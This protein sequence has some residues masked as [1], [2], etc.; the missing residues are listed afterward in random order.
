MHG[1]EPLTAPA[2]ALE[3]VHAAC[4]NH[5]RDPRLN[6]GDAWRR[7]LALEA[8]LGLW[9]NELSER[10]EVVQ[11][12]SAHRDLGL[13]FYAVSSGLYRQAFSSL[14]GFL[15]VSLAAVRLSASELERRQ[16]VSG[17]RDVNWA[18][19]TSIETGLYS[20]AYLQEFAPDAIA[21]A[22]AMQR[23]IKAAYRRCSEYL[24]GDVATTALLPE[25]I[26]YVDEVVVEWRS[27]A[28]NSLRVLHHSMFVRYYAE[29]SPFSRTTI[30]PC[31]EQHLGQLKSVRRAL[32][33]P[34]EEV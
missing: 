27:V 21:D 17:R 18:Q 29:L 8:D 33:L 24:H 2:A 9:L 22:P 19:I 15:E 6:A 1:S 34:I 16:W 4:L 30:E 12:R 32:G 28:V 31:L 7:F 23:D 13:S 26:E 5:L 11:Y 25:G 3:L 14:R 10:P 20:H